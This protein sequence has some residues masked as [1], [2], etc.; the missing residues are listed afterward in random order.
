MNLFL[1]C[2]FFPVLFGFIEK[3]YSMLTK[4]KIKK[5][6]KTKIIVNWI[7]VVLHTACIMFV[8]YTRNMHP[9]H[10]CTALLTAR[11]ML[12]NVSFCQYSYK[13]FFSL[14]FTSF[15]SNTNQNIPFW[16]LHV[17]VG[18]TFL[19]TTTNCVRVLRYAATITLMNMSETFRQSKHRKNDE[20]NCKIIFAIICGLYLNLISTE[21]M[22]KNKIRI[23]IACR[24]VYKTFVHLCRPEYFAVAIYAT[25][26]QR[27]VENFRLFRLIGKVDR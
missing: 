25:T 10:I 11:G 24:Y 22:K 12:I 17:T 14:V 16:I 8:C 15:N 19:E 1:I 3:R 5:K 13:F 26:K 18:N 2:F 9:P 20:Q 21:H 23:L 7:P 4:I 6:A 27:H